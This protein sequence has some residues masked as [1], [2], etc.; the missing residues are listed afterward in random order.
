MKKLVDLT[1]LFSEHL[2][3][4]LSSEKE[5][6][7]KMPKYINK[8]VSKE[9]K[10]LLQKNMEQTKQHAKRLEDSLAL[11]GENKKAIECNVMNELLDRGLHIGKKSDN[12]DVLE[13]GLVMSVQCIKHFEIASY[14]TLVS[15]A[16]LLGDKEVSN[17]L[18]MTLNEEKA[19]DK[20][21]TELA[22]KSINTRAREK[23]MEIA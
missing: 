9:L 4:L 15:F 3:E 20:E 7:E 12:K 19:L 10:S 8:A 16:N 21:M 22:V 11:L 5:Q 14:G 23:S 6:I 17:L 2:K 1:D 18:K 13:A